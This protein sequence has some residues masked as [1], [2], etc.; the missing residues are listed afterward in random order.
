MTEDTSD[1]TKPDLISYKSFLWEEKKKKKNQPCSDY[2][3]YESSFLVGWFY[4]FLIHL[5]Q[6]A[7]IFE[8]VQFLY[9]LR[10]S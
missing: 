4:F 6:E 5:R 8:R 10:T 9:W 7:C 3:L 1:K 2:L